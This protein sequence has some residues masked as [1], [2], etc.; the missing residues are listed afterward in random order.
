MSRQQII[1]TIGGR[2]FDAL[3]PRD[4]LD[5]FGL[6]RPGQYGVVCADVGAA[7][8]ALESLGATPFVHVRTNAPGWTEWGEKKKVG[9]EM[10][11]GY[12]D[13]E[14]IEIL[15]AGHNTQ[16]Y[17]ETIPADG[18]IALHHVCCNLDV[19]KICSKC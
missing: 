16:L 8:N 19:N 10:A 15:G 2:D 9:V 6:V 1:E 4:F 13:G 5:H 11:M 3:V 14:Q 17:S 7:I 18:S 12:S